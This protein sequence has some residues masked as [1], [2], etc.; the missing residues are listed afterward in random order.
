[1]PYRPLE[2]RLL[3]NVRRTANLYD[4]DLKHLCSTTKD[5]NVFQVLAE[6]KLPEE[7][8][9]AGSA[10]QSLTAKY[11]NLPSVAG[12]T[13]KTV[14]DLG[15]D[16]EYLAVRYQPDAIVEGAWDAWNVEREERKME[17]REVVLAKKAKAKVEAEAIAARIRKAQEGE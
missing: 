17:N 4:E 13:F 16:V 2:P 7:K 8:G 1:M 12:F 14:R 10:R 6:F 3:G 15:G 9:K 11:G 5:H